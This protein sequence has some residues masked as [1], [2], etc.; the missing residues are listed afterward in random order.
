M[1]CGTLPCYSVPL[2]PSSRL[3][4]VTGD[5]IR[6][7]RFRAL[8]PECLRG[9]DNS[10]PDLAGSFYLTL[11]R[12]MS[13]HSSLSTPSLDLKSRSRNLARIGMYRDIHPQTRQGTSY[14][15]AREVEILQHESQQEN[16]VKPL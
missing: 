1:A 8:R 11:A 7:A 14:D 12:T 2:A 5:A 15:P 16:N 6:I 3:A 10:C 9:Q 4:E 13:F